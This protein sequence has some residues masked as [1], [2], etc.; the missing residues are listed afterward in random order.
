MFDTAKVEASQRALAHAVDVVRCR[1]AAAAS[2]TAVAG[3]GGAPDDD[4]CLSGPVSPRL[5]V[6]PEGLCL[7]LR[8][9]VEN[10]GGGGVGGGF[11]GVGGGHHAPADAA[12][13]ANG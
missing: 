11:G 4:N 10:G 5:A 13:A 7:A 9:C 12:A 8:A 3:A 2:A 1:A 6:N